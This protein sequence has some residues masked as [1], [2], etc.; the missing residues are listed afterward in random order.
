MKGVASGLRVPV[1]AVAGGT[2]SGKST[3][4]EALALHHPETV[5]L[6]H[7]DDFYV[8]AHDPQRG[9][10]TLS[11]T[12]AETLDWNHPG[13]IDGTAVTAAIDAAAGSG[14]HRLVVV[15]GLFALTL[16][17]VAARASWRV[18]VDTPDDIRLARKILRKIEVQ[19]QDP[20][21]SLRN[22]LLSGRERHAAHVAPSRS[23]ADLVVDGTADEYTMIAEVL[24]LIGPLL[25]EPVL[26]DSALDASYYGETA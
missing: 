9:V 25:A 7:L 10:R 22:Y 5:G 21:L 20:A 1:L 16:P 2:A 23:L 18:Y 14:R 8:P 13:S 17:A 11:A 4:A 6:I 15:E 24:T 26:A 3:L 12:G 19:R